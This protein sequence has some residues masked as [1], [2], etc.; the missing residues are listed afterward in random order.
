MEEEE[1]EEE[2][3]NILTV[4]ERREAPA[5]PHHQV[6]KFKKIYTRRYLK[7]FCH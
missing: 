5:V 4:V 3:Y 7:N 2:R 6:K 1:E